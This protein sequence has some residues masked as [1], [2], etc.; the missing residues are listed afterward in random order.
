MSCFC[1]IFH[2]TFALLFFL[3]ALYIVS[4]KLHKIDFSSIFSYNENNHF[5][6]KIDFQQLRRY[7]IPMAVT[8]KDVAALAGVSPSTVSRTCKDNPSISEETK[9]KV[10]RAMAQLGYEPGFSSQSSLPSTQ[11]TRTIGIILPPSQKRNL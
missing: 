1:I 6:T 11:N 4:K 8:L 2:V 10:R 5:K 7:R 9:E 3:I